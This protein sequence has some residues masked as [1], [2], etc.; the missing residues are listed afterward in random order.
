MVGDKANKT[1]EGQ[2]GA[3]K[4]GLLPATSE[5]PALKQETDHSIF[6]SEIAVVCM[7]VKKKF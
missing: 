7:R 5:E 2:I 6:V 4:V 1:G 3:W